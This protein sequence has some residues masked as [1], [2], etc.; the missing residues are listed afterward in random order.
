MI[1]SPTAAALSA[2]AS[3][4]RRDM[5]RLVW[6]H[7]MSA[8]E[9]ASHFDISWPAVSQQ[10]ATLKEAGLVRER[11]EG[12]YRYYTSDED[13]V[14]PLVAILRQMWSEDLER[15]AR[16]VEEEHGRG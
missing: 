9:L 5:L 14:G 16:I 13:T 1:D 10:L 12:R 2:V 8:G 11:R 3:R 6:D 7:E 15:L 4:R